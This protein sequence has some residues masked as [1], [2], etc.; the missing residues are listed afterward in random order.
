MITHP[1]PRE[2]NL[3]LTLLLLL[4]AA[5]W[6]LLIWQSATMGKQAMGLSMGLAAPLFLTIWIV[7]MVAMMFPSA[8]PMILIFAR[9]SAGK[10]QRGQ[11]FVPTWVFV[12]GYLVA[13][14]LAGLPAYGAAIGADQLAERWFW[15]MEHGER[16]GGLLFIAAGAYQLSPLKQVCLSRCRT[17]LQFV[18]TSWRDGAGGAFRMGLEHGVTCFGCCWLLFLILFPLGVMNI[19]AMALLTLL[20]FAEKSLPVGRQVAHLVA[21]G[22][23]VYGLVVLFIPAALPGAM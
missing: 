20:I 7:M 18:M 4:A 15:L 21:L 1:L 3:I 2:R 12:G 8:A 23:I 16:L 5:A 6:A 9:V 17:P 13:W 19:A 11:P 22:L 14:A 10:Q